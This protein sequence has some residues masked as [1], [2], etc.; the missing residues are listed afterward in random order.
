MRLKK[1]WVL[2]F[3]LISGIQLLGSTQQFPLSD[4]LIARLPELKDE[5]NRVDVLNRISEELMH[6]DVGR[7]FDYAG[8]AVQ[9]AVKAGYDKGI[10][11]AYMNFGDICL[12]QSNYD[13]AAEYLFRGLEIREILHDSLGIA[14]AYNKIGSIYHSLGDYPLSEEYYEKAIK[15][16]RA[17]KNNSLLAE[18]YNKLGM[19]YEREG[20]FEKALSYYFRALEINRDL[21]NNAWISS[22]YGNIGNVYLQQ[23]NPKSLEYYTLGLRLKREMDDREGVAEVQSM[24]GNYYY[25]RKV[26]DSASIYYA[27]A[28]H[29]ARKVESMQVLEG[30]LRGMSQV[31]SHLGDYRNAYFFHKAYKDVSDSLHLLGN[32]QKINQ[33]EMRYRMEQK[34]KLQEVEQHRKQLVYVFIAGACIFLV[35]IISLLY[36]RQRNL[37][38]QGSLERERWMLEKQRL[39]D[40]IEFKNRELTTNVMYLVKKNELGNSIV[41]KLIELKGKMKRENQKIVQEVVVELRNSVDDNVWEEFELRFNQVHNGFYD[42][43]N[44]QFSGLTANEKKLCAFLKLNMTTKEISAITH[45][46]SNSIEVA[47]TRL[48]KKLNLS[49]TDVSLVGFLSQ[50]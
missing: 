31:A 34:M 18:N 41:E 46:S 27:E 42:R 29:E 26:Y 32:D 9:L 19:I 35:V 40:E 47:R 49:N 11:S 50:F 13:K 38:R 7:A 39:R 44:E 28:I 24:I 22:N 30:A 4:S 12:I 20:D 14:K 10:A 25:E 15:I 2:F 37:I 5:K 36:G 3:C 23:G 6:S 21:G 8:Q 43:L 45:Q 48:R 17:L 16:N 33:I 1:N